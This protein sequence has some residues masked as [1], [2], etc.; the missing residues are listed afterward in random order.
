[1]VPFRNLF[2]SVPILCGNALPSAAEPKLT[3]TN[4]NIRRKFDTTDRMSNFGTKHL[5]EFT[6]TSRG[7][8]LFQ[9]TA[10]VANTMRQAGAGKLSGT[11]AYRSGTTSKRFW[12]G[13]IKED[14]EPIRDTAVAIS[15]AEGTPEF[16]DQF[17]L[18]RG[19]AYDTMLAAARAFL[20]DATP[21]K[22]L[23]IEFEM[24]ED[25]LE[26]L[27]AD[28]EAF[29]QADND[30]DSALGEQVGGTANLADL[31][32]TAMDL[33]KQLNA[34]VRNKFKGNPGILA[35]WETAQHLER[36]PRRAPGQPEA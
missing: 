30:Q 12:Y 7:N 3:M 34:I 2:F 27:A 9:Q 16:D 4:D 6:P 32:A 5:P 25:F 19:S 24:P 8:R 15:I 20:K 10:T 29:E 17:R 23:F 11:Q 28:I 21:H 22:D 31:A 13:E 33:R 36:S 26:D 35:Q 14:L 18:P 1:M